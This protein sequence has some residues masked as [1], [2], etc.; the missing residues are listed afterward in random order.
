MFRIDTV[1]KEHAILFPLADLSGQINKLVEELREFKDAETDE[2]R[3]K[4]LADCLIVCAGIYRF[5]HAKGMYKMLDIT[6]IIK[7][8]KYNL[9][10]IED[11]ANCKWLINLNRKWEFKDGSYHHIGIDGAE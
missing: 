6:D 10:E 7:L 4:E 3:K 1:A 9:T 8:R 2:Q 11:L 5:D